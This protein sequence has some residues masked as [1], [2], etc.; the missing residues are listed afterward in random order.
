VHE[1]VC[2]WL[3]L[4]DHSHTILS[5]P[6]SEVLVWELGAVLLLWEALLK[7]LRTMLSKEK[8]FHRIFFREFPKK[9]RG[10][11]KCYWKKSMR[12]KQIFSNMFL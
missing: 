6:K 1:A 5:K 8:I 9:K 11:E 4:R 2:V 12:S 10:A 7:V 3:L